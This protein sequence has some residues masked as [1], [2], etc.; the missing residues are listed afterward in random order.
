MNYE[1]Q[2]FPGKRFIFRSRPSRQAL[3]LS[4]QSTARG[5]RKDA[6]RF[7]E[8]VFRIWPNATRRIILSA[9][10][11]EICFPQAPALGPPPMWIALLVSNALLPE[12]SLYRAD[13]IGQLLFLL[14]ACAGFYLRHRMHEIRYALVG[15]SSLA[16]NPACLVAFFRFLTGREEEA[17]QCVN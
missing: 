13:F 1:T 3:M 8:D 14:W 9:P 16:M 6:E 10:S 12:K 17:W 4:A 7:S 2:C 15:Y 11:T 5:I